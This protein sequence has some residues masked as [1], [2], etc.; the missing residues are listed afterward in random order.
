MNDLSAMQVLEGFSQLIDDKFHMDIL[1]YALR[2]N[3]VQICFHIF[4]DEVNVFVVF[5]GD[6]FVQLYY[7]G[8]IELPQ[9]FYLA[10]G[11]LGVSG[12]L[13]GVEYLFECEYFFCIFLFN[14]PNVAV[15]A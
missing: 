3:V 7:I 6:G 8:V 13:K 14:F 4:K 5:S 10:I 11:A 1:K 9:D 12:V 2:D 15:S